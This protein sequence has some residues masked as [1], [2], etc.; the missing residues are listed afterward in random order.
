MHLILCEAI[1]LTIF[2]FALLVWG[3]VVIINVTHPE[4][5]REAFSHHNIPP[6]DWRVDDIGIVS[7]A[8]APVGFLMW[9]LSR[10]S[11]SIPERSRRK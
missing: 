6:F 8:I 2:I 10:A 11:L 4:W 9:Y 5:V 7:F 3:Y 1:G